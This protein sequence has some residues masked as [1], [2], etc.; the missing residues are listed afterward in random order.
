MVQSGPLFVSFHTYH[1]IIKIQINKSVDFAIGIWTSGCRMVGSDRSTELWRPNYHQLF[2][3]H[4]R[5]YIGYSK[6]SFFGIGPHRSR[7]LP[8]AELSP[9]TNA[10]K[11]ASTRRS[12][13]SRTWPLASSTAGT[14]SPSSAPSSCST[15]SKRSQRLK[16]PSLKY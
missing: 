1:I 7:R 13:T 4:L 5:G 8:D 2:Y 12:T 15:W 9:S 11:A 10:L 14:S 16:L 3:C 6:N